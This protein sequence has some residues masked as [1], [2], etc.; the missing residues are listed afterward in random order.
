MKKKIP[1]SVL[2]VF[3]LLL[4][5]FTTSSE[6]GNDV[7]TEIEVMKLSEENQDQNFQCFKYCKDKRF[8]WHCPPLWEPV[9]MGPCP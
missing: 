1:M 4:M 7:T 8:I 3:T 2:L 6:T 9:D 5:A